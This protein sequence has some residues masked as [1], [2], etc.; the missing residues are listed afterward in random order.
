MNTDKTREIIG[1]H[2]TY[3]GSLKPATSSHLCHLRP[4][5]KPTASPIRVLLLADDPT[6]ICIDYSRVQRWF[7]VLIYPNT[8]K[9]LQ[10]KV[11]LYRK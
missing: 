9:G 7:I 10:V 3:I 2:L 4:I 1:A 11:D 6:E 8:Y 5:A